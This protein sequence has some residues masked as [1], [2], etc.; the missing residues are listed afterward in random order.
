MGKPKPTPAERQVRMRKMFDESEDH[1]I[2]T[3]DY[4]FFTRPS[5]PDAASRPNKAARK[6]V[7][8]RSPR[9]PKRS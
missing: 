1:A 5:T 9:V 4:V 7:I 2:L 8:L 3:S 6:S